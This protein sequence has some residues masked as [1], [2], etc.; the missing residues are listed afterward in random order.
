V[1]LLLSRGA[2]RK[3]PDGEPWS[4]PASWARRRGHADILKLLDM[5]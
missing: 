3:L 5:P 2:S 4:T 1:G